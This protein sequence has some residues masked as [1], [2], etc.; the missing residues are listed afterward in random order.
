VLLNRGNGS[1]RARLN[2]GTGSGPESVAIGDLNGDGKADLIAANYNSSSVGV[3][4]SNGNG[5]F[6]ASKYTFTGGTAQTIAVGD[7]NGDGK[8]DLALDNLKRAADQLT[9]NSVVQDHYGEVLFKLGRYDEAVAARLWQV[10]ADLVGL[11]PDDVL[12]RMRQAVNNFTGAHLVD[13]ITMLVLRASHDN[14]LALLGEH[15]LPARFPGSASR[16]RS[17]RIS[18]A[19]A[20]EASPRSS[21]RDKPRHGNARVPTDTTPDRDKPGLIVDERATVKG[22]DHRREEPGAS[23][24]AAQRDPSERSKG[25]ENLCVSASG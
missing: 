18:N 3:L 16:N 21:A 1:F 19:S 20:S 14:A 13:D 10:S 8:L 17:M 12:A 4:L 2:Y 7:F 25:S 11:E 22:A 15:C 5:T 24:V 23:S 9:T 6:Q